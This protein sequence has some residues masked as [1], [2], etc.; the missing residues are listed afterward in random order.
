MWPPSGGFFLSDFTFLPSLF[1]LSLTIDEAAETLIVTLNE[2]RTLDAG[3]YLFYFEHI[4]TRQTATKVYAFAEDL[5]A[6]T[7]RYNQFT[8]N[9]SVVF[10]NKPVGE[11][12]YKVYESAV[13]TTDP[14]GLTEVEYGILKLN[15]AT[16]FAYEEY[17]G[18]TSYKAYAG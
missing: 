15:P 17:N 14:T 6:Y 2:K 5:S 13:S 10:L 7:N 9:T 4:T 8:I 1:M 11:W 18:A 3:Y 12:T 16:E